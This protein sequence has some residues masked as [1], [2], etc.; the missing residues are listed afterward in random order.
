MKI[1]FT[2][3]S[4]QKAEVERKLEPLAA[5]YTKLQDQEAEF[6]TR[7]YQHAVN[8]SHGLPHYW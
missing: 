6:E 2:A 8:R 5:E 1:Q 4:E 3:I 7:K